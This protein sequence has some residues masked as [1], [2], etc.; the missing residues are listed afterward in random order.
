MVKDLTPS[1]LS[2]LAK[3]LTGKEAALLV[4]DY[5]TREEK[6]KK[7]YR[8]EIKT[9]SSTITYNDTSRRQEYIFYHE[10]W[11]NCGFYSLDL[12]TSL[13]NLEIHAWKLEGVKQLLYDHSFKYGISRFISMLPKYCTQK[14]FNDLYTQCREKIF[15]EQLP[16]E[17]IAEHEAFERL[18]VEKLIPERTY[19]GVDDVFGESEKLKI[20]FEKYIGEAREN[21]EAAIK[22]GRLE[23]TKVREK[24][25]WYHSGSTFIGKRA[26]TGKSWYKHDEKID[27]GY[28]ELIDDK[29]KL[30]EVYEG[31]IAIAQGIASN[32]SSKNQDEC[33]AEYRRREMIEGIQGD[34]SVNIKDK[35]IYL[36]DVFDPVLQTLVEQTNGCIQQ[37]VNHW[38]VLKKVQN[39]VFDDKINVG[40]FVADKVPN[41]IERPKEVMDSLIKL[42]KLSLGF[43]T[44]EDNPKLKNEEKYRIVT[45][46]KSDGKFVND[47]FDWLINLA[48]KESGFR[49]KK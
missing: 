24:T 14:Q 6:E 7:D 31:E 40:I 1:K 22:E 49:W 16:I 47:Q 36:D 8:D 37:S 13:M 23:E 28:N 4:C 39:E 48:E 43:F 9:I 38:E 15:A 2:S 35:E 18:K 42:T 26:V 10:M 46:P 20:T 19:Y 12:Q 34:L 21:I 27:M 17:S 5:Y 33:W 32:I 44:F 29:G 41:S 30:V 45:D 3:T 11:R 25:G